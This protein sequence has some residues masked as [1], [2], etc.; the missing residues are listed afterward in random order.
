MNKLDW[1]AVASLLL[2]SLLQVNC[3]Q[4]GQVS[5]TPMSAFPNSFSSR[6]I[7][8]QAHDFAVGGS[9]ADAAGMNGR[10]TRVA[11]VLCSG[12]T[13]ASITTREART[14]HSAWEHAGIYGLEF[15]G[16]AAATVPYW[17]LDHFDGP[18]F[19]AGG[20][21]NDW[22]VLLASYT[23]SQT[24]GTSAGAWTTARLLRHP[25]R[26]SCS[27]AGAG[28]GLLSLG[29]AAYLLARPNHSTVWS[30]RA[31]HCLVVTLPA[32]GATVGLNLK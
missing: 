23:L 19:F 24:L 21:P 1:P 5:G 18:L 15:L 6:C 20:M 8:I 11:G 30:L 25:G 9:Q 13:G 10:G 28:V 31:F 16:A 22:L 32:L 26:W 14:D 3:S 12:A 4:A 17:V 29:P 2:V 7:G 27:L